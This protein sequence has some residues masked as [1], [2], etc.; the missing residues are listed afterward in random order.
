[1]T[2]A[3]VIGLLVFT[4]GFLLLYQRKMIYFPNQYS[5]EFRRGL[6]KYVEPVKYATSSGK[7]IAFYIGPRN[8]R[9]LDALWVCFM[10]NASVALA[11]MDFA[12]LAA[13]TGVAFLLVEYPGYGASEGKPTRNTIRESTE[14]AFQALAKHVKVDQEKLEQ[15]LNILGL[16]IG[17][18]TGLEFATS[19]PVKKII[20][21][22]PFTSML[23]MAKRSVGVPLNQLLFDRYDNAARLDELAARPSPPEVHIFHGTSDN[24]VPFSMGERLAKA[25]PK[26]VTLHAIKGADHNNLLDVAESEILALLRSADT[27]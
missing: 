25:H 24:I 16:S 10:G 9:Q 2:I 5:T 15:N 14:A 4:V 3:V 1:M 12:D 20:L 17:T 26:M 27:R 11:W 19:H 7:Q 22:A 13:E 21:L 23:E 8:G 6:P 18:A